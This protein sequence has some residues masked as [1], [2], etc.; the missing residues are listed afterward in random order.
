ML[1]F[2][3]S[4]DSKSKITYYNSNLKTADGYT[5]KVLGYN[6]GGEN[7]SKKYLHSHIKTGDSTNTKLSSH[8]LFLFRVAWAV[9]SSLRS[10]SFLS[11]RLFIR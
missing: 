5:P 6:A 1:C 7:A 2:V 9:E 4:E 11:P 10:L 3:L 8:L